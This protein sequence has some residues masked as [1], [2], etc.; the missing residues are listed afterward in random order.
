MNFAHVCMSNIIYQATWHRHV[1]TLY[2]YNMHCIIMLH[3]FK[4]SFDLQTNIG[5]NEF[6]GPSTAML[7]SAY[8][9]F[10]LQRSMAFGTIGM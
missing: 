6:I 9:L 5:A 2:T 4:F 3:T 1:Y 7:R 8:K 10:E